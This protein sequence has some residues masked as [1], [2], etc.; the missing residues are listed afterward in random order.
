M[1]VT[2]SHGLRVSGRPGHRLQ[3]RD[4]QHPTELLPVSKSPNWA[5]ELCVNTTH[6]RTGHVAVLLT[7]DS[8]RNSKRQLE[9][10]SCGQ[11]SEEQ[12]RVMSKA[13]VD[14]I[15]RPL[16]AAGYNVSLFGSTYRCPDGR[17]LTH[18]LRRWY[19]RPAARLPDGAELSAVELQLD[20]IERPPILFGGQGASY[21]AATRLAML[22]AKQSAVPYEQL[23]V[24]RFD[25]AP[26]TGIGAWTCAFDA[27]AAARSS[28]H[29]HGLT[30]G[31]AA[32]LLNLDHV[33]AVP[34]G[35]AHCFRHLLLKEPE[36]CCSTAPCGPACS[37]CANALNSL[38]HIPDQVSPAVQSCATHPRYGCQTG[39]SLCFHKM[40]RGAE[41]APANYSC[42][43]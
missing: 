14:N 13:H 29:L 37:F 43:R 21:A 20:T 6:I 31:Q 26:E 22:A 11:G 39:K 40:A 36:R 23:L 9:A 19:F 1:P 35:L 10:G 42:G 30:S 34:G 3:P 18:L 2:G 27:P 15:V 38:A 17:D 4:F 41:M 24:L 16:Q 25:L 5:D 33:L 8:F 7:G 12:Q 28:A 32:G